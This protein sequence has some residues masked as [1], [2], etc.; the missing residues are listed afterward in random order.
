MQDL[1]DRFES[2]G[3]NCEFGFVQ[4]AAGVET[5]SLLR[6]AMVASPAAL[7]AGL[8]DNFEGL[9]AYENLMPFNAEMAFDRHFNMAFHSALRGVRQGGGYVFADPEEDR[10][11][12]HRFELERIIALRDSLRAS[13]ASGARMFV[14]HKYFGALAPREIAHLFA[15]L[16]KHGPVRLMV[17]SLATAEF[18][19]G[20]VREH[21]P[22]LLHGYID[23]FAPGERADDVSFPL[24]QALCTRALE[25]A[26]G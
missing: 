5:P 3:A 4:R 7:T 18:P 2:L 11:D 9:F 12:L 22:G 1:F 8:D 20:T 21:V 6:W 13:L 14:Y 16:R 10:R 17:V 15:A 26:P 24:W 23:R 19:P 25:M